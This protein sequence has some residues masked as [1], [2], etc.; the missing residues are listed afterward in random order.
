MSI[1]AWI[2]TILFAVPTAM[3]LV[4]LDAWGYNYPLMRAKYWGYLS[5]IGFIIFTIATIFHI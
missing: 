4:G 3:L 1:L 2:G 5:I